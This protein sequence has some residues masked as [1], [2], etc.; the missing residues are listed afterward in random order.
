M[1]SASASAY[2]VLPAPVEPQ[3]RWMR[4]GAVDSVMANIVASRRLLFRERSA[5][6]PSGRNVFAFK[7]VHEFAHGG[8]VRDLADTLPGAPDVTPCFLVRVAPGAE[9]HFR[10]VGKRQIVRIKTG[11]KDGGAQ[12][13]PVY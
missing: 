4:Q 9:V 1:R 12:V 13:I 6:L 11:C 2:V 10:L 8:R 3:I 5:Q 7:A